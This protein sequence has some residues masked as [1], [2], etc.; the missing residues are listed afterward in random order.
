M[1]PF[2]RL[3]PEG[4][5]RGPLLNP[6]AS[7]GFLRL[8]AQGAGRRALLGLV[9]VHAVASTREDGLQQRVLL[10]AKLLLRELILALRV[11]VLVAALGR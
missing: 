8:V 7:G 2:I 1:E 10:R 9:G 4:G 11:V 6:V 5:R 3:L